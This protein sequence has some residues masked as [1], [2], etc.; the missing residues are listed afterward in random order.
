MPRA[1]VILEYLNELAPMSEAEGWDNVG[2]LVDCGS[3]I[4]AIM[5]AL[6]IT[7]DVIAEA[8]L[9]GCQLIVSHH[10]VIF[11]GLKS[12]DRRDLVYRMIK[13]NI[14]AISMHTNLDTATGGVNDI[15]ANIFEV[16]NT[17][18]FAG[19]G[20]VGTLKTPKTTIEL[21]GECKTKFNT[22]IKYSDT[23][24]PIQ[25][26]AIIGGVGGDCF[27]DALDAG[28]DCLLTGEISHHE[29]LDAKQM[30]LSVIG[31]GHFASEY[32]V[33]PVLADKLS[34]KFDG[35]RVIISRRGRDPFTYI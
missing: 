14:S 6:D 15:L 33:V 1:D 27:K 7:Y 32:P 8:E 23:G 12:V 18:V 24:K 29:A 13:K 21:A 10:P 11:K 28:A 2:L 22:A 26:L 5:V 34:K 31:A 9:A 25:N 30:G 20:R 35:L 16:E 3:D 19:L 17:K 4:T